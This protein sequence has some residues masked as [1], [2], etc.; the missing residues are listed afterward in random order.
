[1]DVITNLPSIHVYT[2]QALMLEGA[3]GG[4]A[5]RPYG[6][7][8]LETQHVPDAMHHDSFEQPVFSPDRPFHSRTTYQ[9]SLV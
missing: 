8:A 4:A 1:M 2:A 9:F 3:K 6:G 5:Y 7:I